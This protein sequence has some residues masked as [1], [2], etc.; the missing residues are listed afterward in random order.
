MTHARDTIVALATGAG[1]AGVAIV[2][3][4][5]SQ[6]GAALDS[7]TRRSRPAPFVATA[8]LIQHPATQEPLDFGLVLF[9]PPPANYTGEDIAEFHV[10]GGSG[11]IAALI[12]MQEKI[13]K[14]GT[15]NGR[16]FGRRTEATGPEP[17]DRDEIRRIKEAT[18]VEGLTIFDPPK[19]G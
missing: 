15:I 4:S 12:E 8:R 16:E 13:K 3:V 17:F 14:T 6:A 11:V 5:G 9:M 1:R 10:H 2:R 18:L 7:L 19:L